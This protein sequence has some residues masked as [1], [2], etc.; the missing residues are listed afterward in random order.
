MST[1]SQSPLPDP[2]WVKNL[3][4]RE[5]LSMPSQARHRRPDQAGHAPGPLGLLPEPGANSR[6]GFAATVTA[7]GVAIMGCGAGLGIG[8]GVGMILDLVI[9]IFRALLDTRGSFEHYRQIPAVAAGIG[10]LIGYFVGADSCGALGEDGH[11][12]FWIFSGL[13]F[14]ACVFLAA[15]ALD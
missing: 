6:S 3:K 15:M 9:V 1:R 10:S 13:W 7:V 5:R 11:P 12:A 8:M 4:E 2:G 14:F